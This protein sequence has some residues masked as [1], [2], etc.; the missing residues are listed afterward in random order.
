V[1]A[2]FEPGGSL[3][4]SFGTN[5]VVVTQTAHGAG[6]DAIYSLALDKSGKIVAAGECEQANTGIDV[7]VARYKAGV[8]E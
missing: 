8:T 3:D 1:V 7:C 4:T 5:G 2:R 6:Y